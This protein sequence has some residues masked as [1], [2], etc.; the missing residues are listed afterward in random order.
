MDAALNWRA[1]SLVASGELL[2]SRLTG[3]PLPMG[4]VVLWA[5]G[6]MAVVTLSGLPRL[7][8]LPAILASVLV[9]ATICVPPLV[10]AWGA[11]PAAM[12]GS[13]V[14]LIAGVGFVLGMDL[15]LVSLLTLMLSAGAACLPGVAVP[16]LGVMVLWMG[17]LGL[18]A[19]GTD[20]PWGST[21]AL[22]TSGLLAIAPTP[23]LPRTPVGP[24]VVIVTVDALRAD[25]VPWMAT[26]HRLAAR[27]QTYDAWAPAPWTL[28]S[29]ATLMTGVPPHVHGAGKG[30]DG[31]VGLD[32]THPT[33]AERLGRSG[34][35]TVAYSAGNPFTGPRYG[36]TRGFVELDHPWDPAAAP[37]PRARSP[38]APARPL[39]ARV[40]TR[41]AATY[42]AEA[43][44]DHALARLHRPD[45]PRML[46][47]HLM[48]VHL[49]W[50]SA[51]CR[52]EVLTA[53]ATRPALEA[54]PWWRS[55][56]GQACLR[57]GYT[58]TVARVDAALMRLLDGLDLDH[59]VVVFTSDHG[60]ALGDAGVEHGHTLEAPVMRVP[61]VI[62]VPGKKLPAVPGA[63]SLTD[64]APTLEAVLGLPVT[65]P[66]LDLTRAKRAGPTVLS[67][68]LYGPPR[69]AVVDGPWM[70][71]IRGGE[72]R[73]RRWDGP[74]DDASEEHPEV[75]DRLR[76]WAL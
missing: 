19:H 51:P 50:T 13:T 44:V 45:G 8:K 34:W 11:V 66:G 39:F 71:E 56:E 29:L 64:V 7:G 1:I 33:L 53:P 28:P 21:A 54:D 73:L 76:R 20:R 48:D 16:P 37:L 23:R 57:E 15:V 25:A 59:T 26:W 35:R 22:A 27:G 65:L 55:A 67:S 68:T 49:P 60:E 52:P 69:S 32:R 10:S 2:L 63:V 5:V 62:A 14:L 70:L 47:L 3:G 9:A 61:M 17:A 36:L 6:W 38:H 12:V 46:W 41:P 24:D 18:F 58:A 43:L 31:F 72:T 75:V 4:E 30:P 42:D 74:D 40:L